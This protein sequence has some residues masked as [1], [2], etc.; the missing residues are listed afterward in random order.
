M[1]AIY[2]PLRLCVGNI[3]SMKTS[4]K[5]FGR[6]PL[7]PL[8]LIFRKMNILEPVGGFGAISEITRSSALPSTGLRQVWNCDYWPPLFAIE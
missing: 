6:N 2:P 8:E 3:E 4:K 1:C 5:R 7:T